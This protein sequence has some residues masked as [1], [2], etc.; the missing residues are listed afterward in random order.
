MFK[1]KYN[2]EGETKTKKIEE[3]EL[4]GVHVSKDMYMLFNVTRGHC[5]TGGNDV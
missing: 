1:E 3:C 2:S 4:Q 5:G